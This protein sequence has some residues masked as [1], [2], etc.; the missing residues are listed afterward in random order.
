MKT[1]LGILVLCSWMCLPAHSEEGVAL[2]QSVAG[3][4]N[5]DPLKR[6]MAYQKIQKDQKALIGG[7]LEIIAKDDVDTTFN[8]PLHYAVVTIGEL[9]AKEGIEPLLK[10]FMYVPDGFSTEERIPRE[11]Y[12]VSAVALKEIGAP[13]IEY[14]VKEIRTSEDQARRN[15]AAWVIMEVEG[16]DQAL[17]RLNT[18][19]S[20][21]KDAQK[22]RLISSAKYLETWEPRFGNP[23]EKAPQEKLPDEKE[24]K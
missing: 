23:T 8:G 20:T 3:L 9:R 10:R 14:M 11:F 21:F 4:L 12:Y 24:A 5:S 2:N 17:H 13:A 16:K 22:E 6:Q 15:L 18:A 7:L 1:R 19:A